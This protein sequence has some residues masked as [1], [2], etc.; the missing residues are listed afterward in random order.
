MIVVTKR[1]LFHPQKFLALFAFALI[2]AVSAD[3][4]NQYLPPQ[5]AP[6]PAQ[7]FEAAP[8]PAFEAAPAPGICYCNTSHSCLDLVSVFS[9]TNV[10]FVFIRF[11]WNITSLPP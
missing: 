8:A 1:V 5:A 4:S 9:E 3:V 2:A 7:T 6:A 11:I 10:V